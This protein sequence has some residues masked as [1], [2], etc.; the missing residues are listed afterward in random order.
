MNTK[1][2]RE[3]KIEQTRIADLSVN[4]DLAAEVKGGPRD[5]G[6]SIIVWDIVDSCP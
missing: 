1:D 2:N 5:G 3:E 4:E 6:G